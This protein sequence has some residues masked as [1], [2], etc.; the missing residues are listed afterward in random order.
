MNKYAQTLLTCLG[1]LA[2][3]AG[4]SQCDIDFD[5]GDAEF[6]VSPDPIVGE[7]FLDGMLDEPYFDVLHMLIPSNAAGIDSTLPPQVA[8]DSVIVMQDVID[9]TG[10]YSGIVFR[11][12]DTDEFF[13]ASDIGLEIVLNNSGDSPND[14]TFLGGL[15]YCAAIQGTPNRAGLYSMSI[16]IQ[17]WGNLGFGPF[18][19][20]YVFEDFSLRVNCPLIDGVDVVNAN[21]LD[22]TQ[23]TLTVSLA[24]GVVATEIAWFNSSGNE[25]GTGESVTVVNPGTFSVMVTTEDCQSEF[26]GWVV[27]DQGLDCT[28]TATVDVTNADEGEDNGALAVNVENAE[29]SWTATWYDGEGFILGTGETLEGLDAGEFSVLVVDSIGCS[30]E[31]E[32]IEVIAG[33]ENIQGTWQAFPNPAHDVLVIQGLS[34]G[35]AW[36][37]VGLQGQV[38]A[39]GRGQQREVVRTGNFANGMYVLRVANHQGLT[40]KQ[41]LIQH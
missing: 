36:S 17:A 16:D 28:L 26:G 21:S 11:D 27:I 20:P 10:A 23:G 38:V 15:Q 40:F 29:G 30:A 32:A 5:F 18:F 34:L 39:E 13:H 6:G 31:V 8:V 14:N 24:E 19:Q 1:M 25:I 12:V 22:G 37:L 7:S 33:L 3:A 41:V 9:G 2:M 35:S 4:F